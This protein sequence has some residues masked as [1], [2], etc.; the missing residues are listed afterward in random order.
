MGSQN[1]Y[2]RRAAVLGTG[3]TGLRIAAHLKWRSTIPCASTI[4]RAPI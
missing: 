3:V 1:F 4:D 2:V